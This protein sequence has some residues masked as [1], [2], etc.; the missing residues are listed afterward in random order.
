VEQ[1]R[2][3]A[4]GFS[5]ERPG[6]DRVR[7]LAR[8]GQVDVVLGY[9][10]DRLSRKQTQLGLLVEEMDQL[11]VRLA[12]VTEE[13]EDS[14]VGQFIRSAKAFAAEL[15]REKIAERTARGKLERARSG[16]LPQGTGRGMYGYVYNR[17]TG[18]R[19]INEEQAEVAR[20]IFEQF[21]QHHGVS[22][23]ARAL[24]ADGVPAFGGGRWY[25][26]TVRRLLL[27]EAYT[28]R[29]VFRKTG[30]SGTRRVER[31]ESEQVEIP[32]ATP[33]IVSDALWQRCQAILSDPERTRRRSTGRRYELRGRTRCAA[34]DGAMVGQTLSARGK[35][36]SY[37]RCRHAYDSN[38]A[39]SCSA[40]YVRA[41]A[42]EAGLWREVRTVLASPEIVL[43][44]LKRQRDTD[45]Y[46][47]ERGRVERRLEELRGREE[48]LVRLYAL[49]S[50]EEPVIERELAEAAASRAGIEARTEQLPADAGL[51]DDLDQTA[52][53]AVCEQVRAFIDDADEADRD[54]ILE[55]LQIE[56]VASKD[57]ATVRGVIPVD[58]DGVP[59]TPSFITKERSYR[60]SFSGDHSSRVSRGAHPPVIVLAPYPSESSP[61]SV[62][63]R[64]DS[65][66]FHSLSSLL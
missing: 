13:F 27:N 36:Y 17:E 58:D 55:A 37:Y 1:L 16:R 62:R 30:L 57:E 18:K 47:Q 6:L 8:T 20:T 65:L 5:L 21:A 66:T 11:G 19:E 41:D 2:D 64:S 4:S 14:A 15:E 45:P 49:G 61:R 29:T 46:Q 32:G 50:V 7:E 26:L 43:Q 25:P 35:S 60:C 48:R 28:G 56:V 53:T 12:F 44:E 24:N 40:R 42:L 9:A 34:C 59:L 51:P 31:P 63:P 52:L 54:L 39:R 23:I 3:T 33:R 38:T 10:L 22:K